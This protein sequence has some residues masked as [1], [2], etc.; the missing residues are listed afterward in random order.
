MN[1]Y[2]GPPLGRRCLNQPLAGCHR[3][4]RP[5]VQPFESI[6]LTIRCLEDPAA[7]VRLYDRYFIDQDGIGFSVEAHADGLHARIGPVEV[8]KWDHTDPATFLSGLAEDF[9][10]WDGERTWYTNHLTIQAVYH[11][12]GRVALTWTLQPWL[13][14]ADSWRASLTTWLEAGAQ[15]SRLA[16]DM[17]T[18]LPMPWT[19]PSPNH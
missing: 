6:E 19:R 18:F 15:M 8:W 2:S 9:R 1:A 3:R 4:Y 14:R 16:D 17:E 11:S 13:T 12:R 7:H 5:R 10:G